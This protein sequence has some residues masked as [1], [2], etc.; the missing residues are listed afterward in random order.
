M[1]GRCFSQT[2]PNSA[3]TPLMMC[4]AGVRAASGPIPV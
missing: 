1:S 4:A 2:M 3:G